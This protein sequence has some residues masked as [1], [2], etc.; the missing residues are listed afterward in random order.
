[1]LRTRREWKAKNFL[2]LPRYLMLIE[3]L[4]MPSVVIFAFSVISCRALSFPCVCYISII[5]Q[6]GWMRNCTLSAIIPV[7]MPRHG[8][9]LGNIKGARVVS[10]AG[11]GSTDLR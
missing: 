7:S 4:A 8:R 10:H 1:M 6:A 9:R 5:T 2:N 3:V 11:H